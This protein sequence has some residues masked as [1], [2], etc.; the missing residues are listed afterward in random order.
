[1]TRPPRPVLLSTDAKNEAD[2]Q[3]AIVHALLT[4]T[5]DV[6]GILP[7][8]FGSAGSRVASTAEVALLLEL[9]GDEATTVADGADGALAHADHARPSAASALIAA[10]VRAAS[11]RVSIAV[12]GPLTDVASA[13]LEHP[14]LLAKDPLVVWVGGPPYE[15]VVGYS[16]EFNLINDVAAA[17]VVM[18]SGVEVWQIPMSVYTMIGVGHSELEGR[19][20]GTSALGDYLVDQLIAFNRTVEYGPLDFRSLGDSPAVGAVMNPL[21]ARWSLRPPPRFSSDGEIDGTHDDARR[22]RVCEAFDTRWLIEDMFAKL[23]AFGTGPRS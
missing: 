7:A 4:P 9:L 5:L 6:R 10:E 20:R 23:R 15:G 1:M 18:A 22:I 17:N 19:L 8:H 21:A 12:L 14:D 11:E 16:P 2:D 3:F 13:L